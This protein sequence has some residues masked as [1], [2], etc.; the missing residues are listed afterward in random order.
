MTLERGDGEPMEALPVEVSERL[1]RVTLVQGI[2]TVAAE[3]NAAGAVL[4]YRVSGQDAV[5]FTEG[6]KTFAR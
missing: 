3:T 5:L 1:P 4:E 6:D 2:N